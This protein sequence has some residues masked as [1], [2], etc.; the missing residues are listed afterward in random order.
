MIV[1][2]V[3]DVEVEVVVQIRTVPQLTVKCKAMGRGVD[4]A[5][6]ADAAA[7]E[8]RPLRSLEPLPNR[9]LRRPLQHTASGAVPRATTVHATGHRRE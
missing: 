1:E 8:A 9:F 5:V 3:A 6:D 2:D 7:D 4:E